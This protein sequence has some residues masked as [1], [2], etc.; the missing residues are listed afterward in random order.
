[1]DKEII[2]LKDDKDLAREAASKFAKLAE[3]YINNHGQ[4][5]VALAGGGTPEQMH[6]ELAQYDLDWPKIQ[7]LFSDERYVSPAKENSNFYLAYNSLLK[8]ITIPNQNIHPILT[9]GITAQD[10]AKAYIKTI[11]SLNENLEIDAIFL[12][13]GPDG[14][15]ASIFPNS[16]L[17]S[18]A[19]YIEAIYNSPK[20]PKTRIS[21][22]LKL[23]N[24]AK[25]IIFL[26]SGESK[27]L[28][29]K[30]ILKDGLELPAN[31][32]NPANGKL[33]WL[34]DKKAA[35]YL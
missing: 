32:V 19:N 26:A 23:L 27:A 13:I 24:K 9:L 34:I 7:I 10:S 14:H 11:K 5:N 18:S 31:L 6:R 8:N 2:I 21:F 29:I 1:M 16:D 28:A 33:Y 3:Y 25:N 22:T 35:K 17:I 15:T 12:G 30:N 20:A 4:F